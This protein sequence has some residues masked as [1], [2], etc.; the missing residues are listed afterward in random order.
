MAAYTKQ[1][2]EPELTGRFIPGVSYDSRNEKN[3][4]QN[5]A[6][7]AESHEP[8][9]AALHV[10]LLL[11]RGHKGSQDRVKLRWQGTA[12]GVHRRSGRR[13]SPRKDSLLFYVCFAKRG[14]DLMGRAGMKEQKRT[15]SERVCV[16][17][18]DKLSES[19]R[20]T[21]E[22]NPPGI[23]QGVEAAERC[24]CGGGGMSET[25]NTGST[26]RKN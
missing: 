14:R 7:T 6:R 18:H 22:G 8:A 19:G 2:R 23:I 12:A 21:N 13:Y 3:K 17:G 24:V 1:S 26:Q 16:K 4:N 5:G 10:R 11:D 9:P 20:T 25:N 15:T